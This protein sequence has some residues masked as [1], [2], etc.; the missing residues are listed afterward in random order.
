[1]NNLFAHNSIYI[2]SSVRK[3]HLKPFN[4]ANIITIK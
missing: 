3:E 1:M 4:F 2:I